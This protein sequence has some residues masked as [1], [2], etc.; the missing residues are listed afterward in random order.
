MVPPTF[1]TLFHERL[2]GEGD[3]ATM[4]P[5]QAPSVTTPLITLPPSTAEITSR[6]RR[7]FLVASTFL[8]LAA[9]TIILFT[10]RV[11]ELQPRIAMCAGLIVGMMLGWSISARA[12][13][14]QAA[15]LP[16]TEIDEL[17]NRMIDLAQRLER[18]R[19]G[20]QERDRVWIAQSF[21]VRARAIGDL[22]EDYG[23]MLRDQLSI[24]QGVLTLL[25]ERASDDPNMI[26]RAEALESEQSSI[27]TFCEASLAVAA[28]RDSSANDFDLNA[29]ALRI[30]GM[31]SDRLRRCG[32]TV[33]FELTDGIPPARGSAFL[34]CVALMDILT[35]AGNA[36]I[37]RR[38]GA[39]KIRTI[40]GTDRLTLEVDDPRDLGQMGQEKVLTDAPLR[41]GKDVDG[42]NGYVLA[43]EAAERMGVTFEVRGKASLRITRVS[44][45]FPVGDPELATPI[46]A[47]SPE[48]LLLAMDLARSDRRDVAAKHAATG[49]A[50]LET[51]AGKKILVADPDEIVSKFCRTVLAIRGAEVVT[52]RTQREVQDLIS[53]QVFDVAIT[54]YRMTGMS[55]DELVRTLTYEM[56]SLQT[57]VIF[58]LEPTDED[59]KQFMGEFKY[60]V[61]EKP[62][63]E[64][65]VVNAVEKTLGV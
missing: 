24:T 33:N 57:K 41:D 1:I 7:R 16:P 17:R 10:P 3:P 13:A 23:H 40:Y 8:L 2:S 46:F 29:L 4:G 44:M 60:R 62:L 54:D 38:G 18:T 37:N 9:L 11:E 35:N 48:Q 55:V 25:K 32:C 52:A 63:D 26:F 61:L 42:R 45:S 47:L 51:L 15:S 56:A 31:L 22:A 64:S 12:I 49:P 19:V 36:Q 43:I 58:T 28:C 39:I 21:D 59:V 5:V 14:S 65:S 27:A 53:H 20:I 30:G 6:I 50:V 34:T